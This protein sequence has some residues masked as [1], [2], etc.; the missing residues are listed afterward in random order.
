MQ[1]NYIDNSVLT[2][3][4]HIMNI[5]TIEECVATFKA[6]LSQRKQN[7]VIDASK[8]ENITTSGLQLIISLEK[9]L[10]TAGCTFLVKDESEIFSAAFKEAGL[11]NF[12][13]GRK[14]NG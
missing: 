13:S 6:L 4:P 10:S 1:N 11:E 7:V 3:L 8:V 14:Y 5:E 12:L 2:V 9:T